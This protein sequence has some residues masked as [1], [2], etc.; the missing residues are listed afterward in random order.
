MTK[1]KKLSSFE[2][3]NYLEVERLLNIKFQKESPELDKWINVE[4]FIEDKWKSI[5]SFYQYQLYRQYGFWNE[6][7]LLGNFIIPFLATLEWFT[8]DFNLFNNRPIKGKVKGYE[9]HGFVDGVVSKGTFAPETPYFFIQE[10]KRLKK[11]EPD[12]LGQL[13]IAMLT[14]QEINFNSNQI[15]KPL[16]GCYVIG[17]SWRFV[18]LE[19]DSYSL[20]QG[21][22]VTNDVEIQIVWAI[23]KQT[24][25]FI[26][27]QI[28][29]AKE[30]N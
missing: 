17:C 29:E 3:W 24:K 27:I 10:Y 9:V 11:G 7:E 1:S 20:S 8:D 28:Q 14:S 19:N 25:K 4:P 12:P 26:E 5:V 30:N 13:L 2:S 22:D 21:Y 15:K 6:I 18:L 16:Y 23:L